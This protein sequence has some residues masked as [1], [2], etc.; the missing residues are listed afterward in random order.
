MDE[1]L[2]ELIA[3]LPKSPTAL[4]KSTVEK[5][6]RYIPVPT[7]YKILWADIGSFGG[8]PAGVV[9]TDRATARLFNGILLNQFMD[10]MLTSEEQ[11]A[12][13]KAL[14]D[15]EKQLRKLQQDLRKSDSQEADVIKY[16]EPK[17]KAAIDGRSSIGV[18]AE[19][20]MKESMKSIVLKGELAYGL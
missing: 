16:L 2:R 19:N 10:N 15:D 7:D 8:Y 11:D 17:I 9:I 5:I 12:V 3:T 6:H 1:I 13:I 14:D 18:D 4:D 20:E